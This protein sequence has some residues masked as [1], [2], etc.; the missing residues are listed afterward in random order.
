M[1][2]GLIHQSNRKESWLDLSWLILILWAG[3]AVGESLGGDVIPIGSRRELFVD[4]FLID[5][6]DGGQ[7]RLHPPVSAGIAFRFDQP[8]EGVE[9]AYFSVFKD[10]ETY[11]MYY[12]GYNPSAERNYVCYAESRDGK[13][14]VRPSL[15]LLEINGSTANN[16]LFT[17][18]SSETMGGNAAVF[19]DR[20][21]GIPAH[22]RIK[23]VVSTQLGRA[24][25]CY[26]SQDGKRF[27][28]LKQ[29][30]LYTSDLKNAHDS[31]TCVFWSVSENCYVSY[32]RHS[33]GGRRAVA[34]TTSSDF[35]EWTPAVL[36]RYSDTG[37]PT[38]SQHLYTNQTQP[39]FRAPHIYIAL[40]AR[41]FPGKR[42]LTDKQVAQIGLEKV[43]WRDGVNT[44]SK[45]DVSDVGFMTTRGG[46]QYD[47]V[48][49]EAFIRPGQG[50]RH[51]TS[52]S[53]YAALGVVPA[54]DDQMSIYVNRHYAQETAYLEQLTLRL[55]G[56]ASLHAPYSGGELI[57][58]P[59]TYEGD[60][61]V[62]NLSTS[63]AGSLRVELQTPDGEPIPGFALSE[64]MEIIGDEIDR[65]VSW[66]Q[67]PDVSGWAG[68]PLR[69]RFQLKDADL[70]SFQFREQ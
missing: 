50:L 15:G 22:E 35:V 26:V 11:R 7:L 38:P 19:L 10:R 39:Y 36:M 56:F 45:N 28:R 52:R 69:I 6:I 20:R 1:F 9:N 40:P 31:M 41:Y 34:R 37:T 14:W 4:R 8:W 3:S 46:N 44:W 59:L 63:A 30:P 57:T 66:R 53:N 18:D 62:L 68:K 67:G 33:H 54:S 58:K 13:R 32:F 17:P 55:D 64:C 42:V 21:P 27:R 2:K 49:M 47:R 51:W 43:S 25:V 48:F 12:R 23:L 29:E 60:R 24:L 70:Y 61:L 5:R 16:A 65:T